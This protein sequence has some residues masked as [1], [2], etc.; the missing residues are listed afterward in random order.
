MPELRFYNGATVWGK[1]DKFSKETTSTGKA[2]VE[3]FVLC[4]HAQYGNVRVLGRIWG[5]EAVA[6]FNSNVAAGKIVKSSDVRLEGNIQQ[7]SGKNEAIKTT[8]NFYRCE[9]MDLKEY[10]AAFRLTG[11]VVSFS[12]EAAEVEGFRPL[13]VRILQEKK[14]DFERKEEVFEVYIPKIV[15]LEMANDP[16][17]GQTVRLK[18]YIE[19]PEDEFGD[20]TGK[21]LPVVR[22]LEIFTA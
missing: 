3:I 22:K 18:G 20:A 15:L 1:L 7:Y 11:E 2:Y 14:D 10:K 5:G 9:P 19:N 4:Q 8:F 17:P 6:G 13:R 12:D 16:A 21:Q